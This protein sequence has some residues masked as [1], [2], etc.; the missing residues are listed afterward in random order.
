M[1]TFLVTPRM[2]PALRARVERA[3]SGRARAR[4]AAASGGVIE[5]HSRWERPRAARIL[6]I[7][8]AVLIGILALT[9]RWY[10]RRAVE[11][12]RASL[13]AALNERR[14]GLPAGHDT[15]LAGVERW[16]VETAADPDPADVLD[17]ALRAPGALGARL[18]SPTVYVRGAAAE[19]ANPLK[20]DAAARGSI[21]DAFLRC[22]H[23]PP[24]STSEKDL[25]A[26]VRG[27]YFGGAKIDDET[28]GVRRLAE[29]RMGLGVLG[30]A[31]EGS[32]RAA[33]DLGT[34]KR[35][36]RDLDGAPVEQA[37][38]AA[39]AETLLLVIDGPAPREARVALVDL[40][41]KKILFRTRRRVEERARS[42][43]GT[44][45]R[46]DV[47]ACGLGH[48]VRRIMEEPPAP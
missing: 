24:P 46:E 13:I 22:L 3:V 11:A 15:F 4:H 48:D 40:A 20:I 39:A 18:R 16:I 41:G 10:D 23:S 35:L 14:A 32:A 7:A 21:K 31:F 45:H 30:A 27:V 6:P 8:V 25:L 12:E 43:L 1:A 42:P 2:S 9:M 19:L 5:G 38:K 36:R 17:P 37:R 29:A 33:E 44:L 26:K 34:L 28:P 47:E